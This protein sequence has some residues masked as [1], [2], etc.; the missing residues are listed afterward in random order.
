VIKQIGSGGHSV[1]RLV[2]RREDGQK[3]VAKFIR[4][5][6]VWHFKKFEDGHK[7]PLEIAMMKKFAEMEMKETV[8][9]IEHFEIGKRYIII[10]EY[11]G[12]DWIDLYDFI[13]I[14]GPVHEADVRIIFRSVVE[15]IQ[16]MHR[17]GYCHNDIKGKYVLM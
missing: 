10:M 17:L 1:V 5:E 6:N 15:T 16:K 9:Y 13:E 8:Q 3:F 4:K 14:Y 12:D 11:L 2:E 7:L